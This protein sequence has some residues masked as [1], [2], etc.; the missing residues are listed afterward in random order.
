[1][2][3]LSI[4]PPFPTITDTDGQ[5][6]ENGYIWIGTAN[7]PAQ[8]NPISVYWDAALT[9]PAAQPIRTQGG[10]PVNSG[11]PARLYV[12][13]D[14]SILVQ[15]SRGTTVYSAP[16]A[17][18]R[19]GAFIISSADIS[20]LQAGTGAV[21][22]S[23]QSKMRDVVSVKDFGAVGDG[24]TDD[25][26]AFVAALAA[27]NSVY[28]PNGIYRAKNVTIGTHQS[29]FGNGS[30]IKAAPSATSIFTL[31]GFKPYLADCYLDDSDSNITPSLGV[32]GGVVVVDAT[33]PTVNNCQFVNL[34]SG[35][36]A[37]VSSVIA[38]NQV[39]KGTFSNLVFDTIQARGIYVG[40]N[41]NS[42]VFDNAQMY[43]GQVPSGGKAIPKAGCIGF[44]IVSTGTTNAAGGHFISKIAVLEAETGF[45]FTDAQ[46]TNVEQCI[47]DS[48]SGSGFQ[49]NNTCNHIKFQN[50]FAGT[51]LVGFNITTT[52]LNIWLDG[53]DTI[54]QGVVPPWGDP[55]NF[56]NAGTPFDIAL[57]N[58][59]SA[60]I[61]T[62]F[63]D[64]YSFYQ[65]S[66]ATISFVD[67]LA[68]CSGTSSTPAGGS[69]VYLGV[70]G[71]FATE[72]ATFV[73]PKKGLLYNLQAQSEL[74]PSAGQTYTYTARVQFSDS[75]LTCQ[76]AGASFGSAAV[77]PIP[78]NGGENISVKLVTSATATATNH[79]VTLQVKYFG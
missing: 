24:V 64:A 26:A 20:F 48:L 63:S 11:T 60:K 36:V 22:R 54:F 55:A 31:T 15:N 33:Y 61:G 21:V 32:N 10:Y 77:Y 1:M 29:V 78:F 62:W 38:A 14:Y 74:A 23:A 19:Y 27:S 66:T 6:L 69:T 67:G 44:Q 76:T 51:C 45:D 40:P 53:V 68:L 79:R 35:L 71:D 12:N 52:S 58:T 59:A 4:Q 50:C 17:T 8:T 46:L 18:E 57:R 65:D 13:S 56:F 39:T 34:H 30:I 72:T 75:L 37:R 43:V 73:A 41:V 47:A 3:A 16:Q 7:L 25:S 49:L 42:C 2:T 5:P 70:L 9:Q 28:I